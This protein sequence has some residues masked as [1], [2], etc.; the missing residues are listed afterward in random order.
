MT[1]QGHDWLA[2]ACFPRLQK[3]AFVSDVAGS[4]PP[5][6]E[7]PALIPACLTALSP[8]VTKHIDNGC[9]SELPKHPAVAMQDSMSFPVQ[10]LVRLDLY[11]LTRGEKKTRDNIETNMCLHL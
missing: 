5:V 4:R 1:Q 10:G 8:V 9:R 6:W 7:V 11:K 2:S 3:S